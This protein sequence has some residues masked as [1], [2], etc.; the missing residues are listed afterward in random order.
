MGK[1]KKHNIEI[2]LLAK[3]IKCIGCMFMGKNPNFRAISLVFIV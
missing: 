2:I 3:E 1:N